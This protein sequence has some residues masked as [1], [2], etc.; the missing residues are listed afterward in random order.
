MSGAILF[1][2]H[3][4]NSRIRHHPGSV[5]ELFADSERNDPRMQT[6]LHWA[7][8]YPCPVRRVAHQRLDGL[9]GSTRHQ[10]IVARVSPVI[11]KQDLFQ[12]VEERGVD[13]TLL[14]LDGVQDPH[15][16]GACLRVADAM[17]VQAVITPKDGSAP[18][19]S[20]VAKIS[21]GASEWMPFYPV[22]NLARTLDELKE[23]GVWTVGLDAGAKLSLEQIAWTQEPRALA[24]VLGSEERG[25]RRLTREHCDALVHI[26]MLG[27]VES[28][29]VSVA[30]GI[31]L[32]WSQRYKSALVQ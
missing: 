27:Q 13:L 29:N 26:P 10:G 16:L 32:Y 14:I 19:S 31:C 9:T 25:M 17:G 4:I 8:Q 2:F 3:A 1:G 28:L 11:Q 18:L 7:S 22:T 5:I 30:A 12:L 20:A 23:M 15:N 6:I 24:W 21:S